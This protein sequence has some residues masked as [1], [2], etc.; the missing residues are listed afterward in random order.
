MVEAGGVGIFTRIENTQVIDFSTRQKRSIRQNCA[1]L[2]RIWNARFSASCPILRGNRFS[3]EYV[4]R[5]SDFRL[6]S[7]LPRSPFLANGRHLSGNATNQALATNRAKFNL[8][9]LKERRAAELL[10]MQIV[11]WGLRLAGKT[12]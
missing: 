3:D 12:A 7:Q 1:Q 11:K 4:I 2:E 8:V 10:P 6:P 5:P 9:M